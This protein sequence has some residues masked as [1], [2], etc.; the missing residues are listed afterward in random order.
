MAW[1]HVQSTGANATSKAFASN[2]T[3]G[4]LLICVSGSGADISGVTDTQGNTYTKRSGRYVAG[5]LSSCYIWQAIAGSTGANT[6]SLSG[7][8]GAG[9]DG[10]AIGEFSGTH[11]TPFDVENDADGSVGDPNSGN[12]TTSED[13]ELLIGG[14]NLDAA[15]TI[16]WDAAWTEAYNGVGSSRTPTFAYQLNKATGTYAASGTRSGGDWIA[17]IATFKGAG[18]ATTVRPRS[19][20]T[21]GVG[22]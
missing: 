12:V 17:A 2:V 5:Y 6:V 1:A 18:A 9:F 10:L 8:F 21:L 19:L 15:A 7:T 16:T 20:L 22:C 13:D 4:N 3:S 14:M 11:A